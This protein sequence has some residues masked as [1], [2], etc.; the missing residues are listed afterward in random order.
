[1]ALL[2]EPG[3]GVL[4]VFT[5]GVC[6]RNALRLGPRR[7]PLRYIHRM[8]REES[9]REDLLREATALVER[10]EIAPRDESLP[11]VVAGFRRDGGCS[12]FFGE[13]PVYQFNAAGELRRAFSNGR[14]LKSVAG[15]LA[16]LTRVRAENEVQLVRHDLT[17]EETNAFLQSMRERVAQFAAM[18]DE[19]AL[20]VVGQAPAGTDILNRL[21]RWLAESNHDTI[22]NR[23]NA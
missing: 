14:L 9:P 2:C 23:P 3:E 15:R 11:P 16:A 7:P 17:D 12:L 21:K 4:I 20:E 5:A 8:A 18:L 10:I 1:V 13:D 19:G 22:A 6:F